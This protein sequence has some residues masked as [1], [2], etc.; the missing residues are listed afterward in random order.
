[1]NVDKTQRTQFSLLRLVCSIA[2]VGAVAGMGYWYGVSRIEPP[3][4]AE[5]LKIYGMDRPIRNRLQADY[6]DE[7][8]DLVADLPNDESQWLDPAVINFCYLASDQQ[9]YQKTWAQFLE[10]L[11]ER[12]GKEV[13]YL[14]IDSTEEQLKALKEG[15]L[16]VTGLNTGATPIAV[17]ACGFVP[18]CGFGKDG[19]SINYTMKF[20]VPQGSSITEVGELA[21]HTLTLT[22]PMSNSGWKAPL[23]LLKRDFQLLP[24]RDFAVIYSNGHAESL[25][26]IATG[27]HEIAAVAGDEMDLAIDHGIVS[28]DKFTVIYESAPFPHNVFGHL[29]NLQPALAE[30]VRESFLAFPWAE[31]KLEAEFSAFGAGEFVPISYKTDLSLIREIDDAM[32]RRHVISADDGPKSVVVE[33]D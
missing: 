16:H 9:R 28:E 32:G 12:T 25:K 31:S 29:H 23:T 8:G 11:A 2:V 5:G 15:K 14:V 13:K 17:N 33:P 26:S 1:M 19:A 22:N 20:I 27:A 6:T 10:F 24:V 30:K 3:S 18:V 4:E 21:G 7:D